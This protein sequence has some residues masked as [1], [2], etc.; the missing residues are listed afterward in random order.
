M[1]YTSRIKS[2]CAELL[3]DKKNPKVAK[4]KT[5][6]E[7]PRQVRPNTNITNSGRMRYRGNDGSPGFT[8]SRIDK[9]KS[10]QFMP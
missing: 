7:K 1:P 4:S 5:N 2:E 10:E 6:E 8:K 3:N 9:L